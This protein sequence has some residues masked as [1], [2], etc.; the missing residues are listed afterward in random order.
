[1]LNFLSS[2]YFFLNYHFQS[3]PFFQNQN[4]LP[5]NIVLK[6]GTEKMIFQLFSEK[7]I[8][9]KKKT[10]FLEKTNSEPN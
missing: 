8:T 10:Y 4:Q 6:F 3:V 9:T 5:Q 2:D 1:M 7:N